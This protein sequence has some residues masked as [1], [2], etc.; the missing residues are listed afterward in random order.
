MVVARPM[1]AAIIMAIELYEY[2]KLA[3]D[4]LKS[5]SIL[6]GGV[7][8]G[9]SRTA[10]AYYFLKDCGGKIKINGKGPSLPMKKP[11]DLYIIT[12]AKKRDSM[13]WE[14]E[15]APF[16]LSTKPELSISGVK[17]TV[18]SWNNLPKYVDIKNAFFIFDEQRLVGSGAWVKSF[19]KIVK[20]YNNWILLSA[21]PGDTWT[22]YIPVFVANGFYKN[23]TEFLRRHAV[24][25]RFTKYPKIEKFIECDHLI[26]L[27]DR[28]TVTM[29]YS[30]HTKAQ[31]RLILV[32]FD[33]EVFNQVLVKRWNPFEN[34]P[35]KAIG[36]LCYL[37][38]KVVNRDSARLEAIKKIISEHPKVIIFYNFNYELDI[39]RTLS[40][41]LGMPVSE[42][43]GRKHQS[44]PK[45]D[46]W[47]YL[48]QYTAGAEGWNCIE[49]DTIIFYSQ[50][51]SYKVMVQAAGRIDRL[52]SP[53][54]NLYYYHIRS[55]SVIDLSIA[56]AIKTK[57]NFNIMTF[58]DII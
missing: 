58:K 57:K 17:V 35:V 32:P 10:I 7:G 50:N 40:D 14:E 25:N 8:S 31:D 47:A 23:R 37:M 18:D 55:S 45:G 52:N 3:I 36:E 4:E 27:R 26:K 1:V 49:T 15:C 30:K 29:Y 46:R 42:W 24:Y 43:N 16:M 19:L 5:G 22:D 21:T 28:I 33:K 13:E 56:K 44:I 38:R 20:K 12:T 41:A 48:V 54:S 39:L 34:R 2:Q 11:K 53:F 6:C 51:Y 9:K